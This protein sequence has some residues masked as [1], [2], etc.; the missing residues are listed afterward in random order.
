VTG[1]TLLVGADDDFES[2]D[3]LAIERIREGGA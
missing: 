3:T 1:G 2:I